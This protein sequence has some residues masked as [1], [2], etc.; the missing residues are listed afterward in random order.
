MSI[1]KTATIVIP[2]VMLE[3]A[4]ASP[5]STDADGY[6]GKFFRKL[7]PLQADDHGCHVHVVGQIF[8]AAGIAEWDD[9]RGGYR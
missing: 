8:V 9:V 1:G 2:W 6:S 4:V 5:N 3:A 7:F